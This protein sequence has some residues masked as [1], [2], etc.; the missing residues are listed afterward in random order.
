[1]NITVCI[2]IQQIT[3]LIY[4]A[5]KSKSIIHVS[6]LNLV[7]NDTITTPSY[8]PI[9]INGYN[10]QMYVGTD[11][12]IIL[13]IANKAIINTF[14]GCNGNSANANIDAMYKLDLYSE[15]LSTPNIY[16]EYLSTYI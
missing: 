3:Y 6:D 14:N 13:I 7:L 2:I 4:G 9:S 5:A 15:Y 1:M 12:G 8:T 11:Q 16:S 10:N